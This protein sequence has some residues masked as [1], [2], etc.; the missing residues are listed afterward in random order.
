M[1]MKDLAGKGADLPVLV[2]EQGEVSVGSHAIGRLQGFHFEVD[3]AARHSD[4]KML[5]AAAERRLGGEFE[6]RAAALVADEDRN[7]SLRTEPGEPVTVLWR[8]HEVSRLGTGK[9]LLSP[10]ILLD[11]RMERLSERGRQAI[12]DRLQE[13]LRGQVERWLG[14][15][16]SAGATA[17]DPQVPA[18]ARSVLAM[19]VDEGGIIARSEV[20]TPLARLDRQQRRLLSRLRIR[21]GSLDLFMPEVLKPEAMRWRTALRAAAAGLAMPVLPPQSSTVLATPANGQRELLTSLGF[22]V[23]GPQMLRV[24]LVERLA[25]HAHEVRAGK[26]GKV[27]DDAL[28]TSLGLQPEAIA[29][30]MK[31]IGFRPAASEAG[32]IWRGKARR[33]DERTID[34]SHAFAVLAGLRGNG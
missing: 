25:R 24:D 34:P 12:V 5:L 1:L 17:R 20:A 32:W 13:W 28:V 6:R 8:G 33:R 4:R 16:R 22:R 21:I 14:P 3:P 15:L 11:R 23:L 26:A 30:L 10:R 9:N 19:L 29:R 2:D 18:D 7:F 27:V 31:D